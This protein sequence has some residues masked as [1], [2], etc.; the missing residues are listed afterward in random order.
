[1]VVLDCVFVAQAPYNKTTGEA[2]RKKNVFWWGMRPHWETRNSFG[3]RRIRWWAGLDPDS[4]QR[5]HRAC[6]QTPLTP[7]DP[8]HSPVR[9]VRCCLATNVWKRFEESFCVTRAKSSRSST[10]PVDL[11]LGFRHESTS[12]LF[13]SVEVPSALV[14]FLQSQQTFPTPKTLYLSR[15]HDDVF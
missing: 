13:P 14:G 15:F 1:M 10:P 4:C 5:V 2:F 8:S 3:W 6:K 9:S 7:L 12:V 11:T